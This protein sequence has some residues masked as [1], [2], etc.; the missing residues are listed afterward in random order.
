MRRGGAI[1]EIKYLVYRHP[2]NKLGKSGRNKEMR[3]NKYKEKI[4]RVMKDTNLQMEWAHDRV[5]SR[6]NGVGEN[7]Q[8]NTS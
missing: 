3:K 5:L 8:L 6:I 2:S 4:L 1:Q 7:P